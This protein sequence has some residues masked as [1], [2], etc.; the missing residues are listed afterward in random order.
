MS[1][2]C[3]QVV[4]STLEVVSLNASIAISHV[5]FQECYLPPIE[6]CT[7]E[8]TQ[9]QCDNG[10]CT[11]R[12]FY[13]DATDDCGDGSDE[14]GC[15][16]YNIYTFEN[17]TN[18]FEIFHRDEDL[19][20]WWSNGQPDMLAYGKTPLFD[21][22][23]FDISF[24]FL[25]VGGLTPTQPVATNGTVK[26]R[27]VSEQFMKTDDGSKGNCKIVFYYFNMAINETVGYIR[28]GH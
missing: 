27:I 7:D 25:H 8:K 16:S 1:N 19:P 4:V 21:H 14:R 12:E 3:L 13:C 9:F 24:H 23:G 18:E 26:G 28:S 2:L 10:R 20:L 6:N 17:E 22:T 15:Q 11:Q 5:S